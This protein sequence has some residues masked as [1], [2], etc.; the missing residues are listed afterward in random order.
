MVQG[1]VDQKLIMINDGF[2]DET[3]LRVEQRVEDNG[4]THEDE[5]SNDVV[6]LH[7]VIALLAAVSLLHGCKGV[8]HVFEQK[9]SSDYQ[10]I[11]G[12]E[13]Q[14]ERNGVERVAYL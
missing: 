14:N 11:W 7:L 3:L 2:Q 6:V 1:V 13:W 8:R 9:W 5:S 4:D 10:Q 12:W